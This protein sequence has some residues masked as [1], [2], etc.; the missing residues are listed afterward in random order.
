MRTD[1]LNQRQ[2][3]A[4]ALLKS[5]P[6]IDR[7]YLAGGTALALHL[8]HRYS[9]DFDFFSDRQFDEKTLLE[10]LQNLGHCED[11]RKAQQ[12]LFLKFEAILCSFI[13]YKY[14]LLDPPS[15]TPWG[16][17]IVSLR[18]I[19]AMK[20]MAIGDRGQRRD[21]V[22]LYFIARALG[23]EQVWRDFETKYA[24]TGYDSYHFLRALTYFEDAEGDPALEMIEQI[25]W[26]EIKKHLE[27]EVGKIIL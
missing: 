6:E 19:G 15:T 20:I 1:L 12:T 24:G 26:K 17:G 5:C 11:V 3:P 4:L 10:N 9:K 27:K 23:I 21:F 25:E 16:F 8:G 7:F 2:K 22:D 13:F 18:E 14:P